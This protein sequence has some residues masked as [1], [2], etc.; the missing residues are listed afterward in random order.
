M[1]MQSLALGDSVMNMSFI[2]ILL[3]LLGSKEHKTI[4]QTWS[5][6]AG[7]ALGPLVADI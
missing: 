1:M 7:R 3:G 6:E 5:Y 4:E 2:T